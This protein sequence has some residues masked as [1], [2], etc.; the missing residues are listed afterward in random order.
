MKQINIR[1]SKELADL[2]YAKIARKKCKI[3]SVMQKFLEKWVTEDDDLE[4]NTIEQTQIIKG[5]LKRLDKL[6][7]TLFYGTQESVDSVRHNP[8]LNNHDSNFLA[9]VANKESN[10]IIPIKTKSSYRTDSTETNPQCLLNND[11]SNSLANVASK[12][13]TIFNESENM[14]NYTLDLFD[15]TEQT[16]NDLVLEA[17]NSEF[18]CLANEQKELPTDTPIKN[19]LQLDAGDNAQ[20]I[21]EVNE[22]EQTNLAVT[23]QLTEQQS[24]ETDFDANETLEQHLASIPKDVTKMCVEYPLKGIRLDVLEVQKSKINLDSFDWTQGVTI[25]KIRT[26]INNDRATILKKNSQEKISHLVSLVLGFPVV[27]EKKDII[28]KGKPN[29]ISITIF[30]I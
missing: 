10:E 16:D 27:C 28:L 22:I 1:V 9:N 5:I 23:E 7:Q 15:S 12:E 11:D 14:D 24:L 4:D 20:P 2:V 30:K 3:Q 21:N 26:L 17:I 18:D 13:I 19:N 29:Q 8:L 6:E 25:S